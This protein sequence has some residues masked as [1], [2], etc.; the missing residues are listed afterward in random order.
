MKTIA[1]LNPV[2]LVEDRREAA[3]DGTRD[4]PL[5]GNCVPMILLGSCSLRRFKVCDSLWKRS[6]TMARYL[7]A[8]VGPHGSVHFRS[9]C[10]ALQRPKLG[11]D[12]SRKKGLLGPFCNGPGIRDTLSEYGNCRMP[13]L[14]AV[15]AFRTCGTAASP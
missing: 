5:T 12:A 9:F 15:H 11:T 7:E 14:N 2:N 1:L 4:P 10:Q 3:L 13:S 6:R 8:T